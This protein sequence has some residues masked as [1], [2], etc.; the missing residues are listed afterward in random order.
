[1][2]SLS[3]SDFT[4]RVF[5]YIVWLQ[6]CVCVAEWPLRAPVSDVAL[7]MRRMSLTSVQL[8]S[9]RVAPQPLTPHRGGRQIEKRRLGERER[10]ETEG[11][12]KR[13]EE[14]CSE[15]RRKRRVW[16]RKKAD[17]RRGGGG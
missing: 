12:Q 14:G 7:S 15:I 6:P 8:L 2:F 11:R 9:E 10:S 4:T 3:Q 16:E 1:M 13:E 17:G 5:R